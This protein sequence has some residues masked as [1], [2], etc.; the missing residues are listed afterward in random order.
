[1]EKAMAQAKGVLP[2]SDDREVLYKNPQT[3]GYFI[4]AGLDPAIDRPRVEAW[5]GQIDQMVAGLVERLPAEH[6]QEKGA[7]VA[8]VAVGFAPTF[9]L[10]NGNPRFNPA[11]DPPAAFRVSV[12]SPAAGQPD[13]PNPPVP[14]PAA[15]VLDSDVLFYVASVYEARVNQFVTQLATMAPDVQAVTLDRGYQRLD[16]TEPFGYADGLRNIRP[17]D[18][19]PRVVFVDRDERQLE[20]PEWADGG[21][22]MAF[23]R[24]LQQGDNF[25]ALPDDNA[26]DTVIGRQKDGTRLDLVGQH[27]AARDEP[28]EPAPNLPPT[29]HVR[30]AG[31]REHHDDTQIFRRGLPFMETTSDGHL[32]V[33]LNFCS[34]QAS[35]EQFDV[36]LNDWITNP[37]FPT[38]QGGGPDAL[39]DPARG[40]TVIEKAGVF[41][42]PPYEQAG[43]AAALF[44]ALKDDHGKQKT[45]KL[46]VRKRVTDPSD[47]SKRFERGGFVF[48]VLDSTGQ[49]V[50]GQFTSDSTGRA[51]APVELTIGESYTLQ[52]VTSNFVQNVQLNSVPFQ[53]DKRHKELLIINQV[54]QPNTGYGS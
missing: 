32:R 19:R 24:I 49:S 11:V 10:L 34:F 46:V 28:S 4:G 45:G 17:V 47:S 42:V 54:T 35:L 23:M 21:T 15:T 53:M 13:L 51:I 2:R 44:K 40:L 43:L 39:L 16:G 38:D 8:A 12:P 27:V 50:G 22:Y 3:C 48:Q 30:K 7:K 41:F 20:E 36:I 9:F 14:L 37:R 29:A 6:G 1:M 25:K 5:L 26:R 18:R 31:P 33:G 52:E